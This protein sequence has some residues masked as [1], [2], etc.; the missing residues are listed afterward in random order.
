MDVFFAEDETSMLFEER[1][2]LLQKRVLGLQRLVQHLCT[3]QVL[4]VIW[5]TEVL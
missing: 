1:A 3:T 5:A 2:G 4:C